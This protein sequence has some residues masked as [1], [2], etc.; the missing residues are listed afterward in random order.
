MQQIG[1]NC[2]VS[3]IGGE[4]KEKKKKLEQQSRKKEGG[5]R[6]GQVTPTSTRTG[7][8]RIFGLDM[9]FTVSHLASSGRPCLVVGGG[10]QAT[11][12]LLGGGAQKR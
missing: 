9:H 8:L 6:D 4:K 1:R 10:K 12:D 11:Q 5:E 3:K 2:A 7:W